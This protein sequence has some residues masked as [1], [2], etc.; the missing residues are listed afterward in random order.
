ML[1]VLVFILVLISPSVHATVMVTDAFARA[2]GQLGQS[3]ATYGEN[4]TFTAE[5]SLLEDSVIFGARSYFESIAAADVFTGHLGA[6]AS[7]NRPEAAVASPHYHFRVN[8]DAPTAMTIAFSVSG[9]LSDPFLTGAT[10]SLQAGSLAV[11]VDCLNQPSDCDGHPMLLPFFGGI[12][13]VDLLVQAAG[14]GITT[15]GE[16]DFLNSFDM[17]IIL[18]EGVALPTGFTG[19][20]QSAQAQAPE[21]ASLALLA[22]G[23]AG[24]GFSRRNRASNRAAR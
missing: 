21:P 18:P 1:R 19:L 7:S 23:F 6:F 12:I 9:S 8:V 15:I 17:R 14:F 10:A 4:G 22:I 5:G 20:F 24:L 16:A 2:F 13:S 3:G 11:S